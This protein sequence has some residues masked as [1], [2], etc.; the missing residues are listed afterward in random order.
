VV[1]ILVKS[2]DSQAE[3]AFLQISYT[4]LHLKGKKGKSRK[5]R[6]F[7]KKLCIPMYESLSPQTKFKVIFVGYLL[8]YIAEGY[9]E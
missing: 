8:L 5:N 2:R 6:M 3:S 7:K 1:T 4:S 9:H